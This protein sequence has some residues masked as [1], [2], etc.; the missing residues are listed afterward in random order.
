MTFEN[1][2]L[3]AT[4]QPWANLLGQGTYGEAY[5]LA[6]GNVAKVTT[7]DIEYEAALAAMSPAMQAIE[8]TPRIYMVQPYGNVYV[9]VREPLGDLTVP[10][11]V[12][13]AL[14][15]ATTRLESVDFEE[16][17]DEAENDPSLLT[18]LEG[19][20]AERA[21]DELENS[22]LKDKNRDMLMELLDNILDMTMKY[23]RLGIKLHD[24]HEDNFGLRDNQIVVRD[25]GVFVV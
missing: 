5:R 21:F 9:I 14:G 6:D 24:L 19:I 1:E 12:S 2:V 3:A 23:A 20:L 25:L 11:K 15:E 10:P 4:G 17:I 18:E 7:S 8:Y 16:M 13:T 22:N